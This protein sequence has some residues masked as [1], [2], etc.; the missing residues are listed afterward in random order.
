M[1]SRSCSQV[2]AQRARLFLS[3]PVLYG[4]IELTFSGLL[5]ISSLP[6]FF[7]PAI[8]TRARLSRR[9]MLWALS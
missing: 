8:F 1:S 4:F 9:T 7:A 2:M 6:Q 3:A 5:A